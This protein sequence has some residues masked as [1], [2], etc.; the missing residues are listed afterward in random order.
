MISHF[1]ISR[2]ISSTDMLDLANQYAAKPLRKV[3][4]QW[5]GLCPFHSEKTGSFYISAGREWFHCKGCNAGGGPIDFVMRIERL[6]FP[7][8]V[9]LLAARAG[10]EVENSK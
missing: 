10:I 7:D 4:A 8:A 5:V 6:S 9:R 2:V 3:G 1:N